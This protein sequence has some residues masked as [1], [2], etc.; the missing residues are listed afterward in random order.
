MGSGS[1]GV[2]AVKQNRKF[3][4]RNCLIQNTSIAEERINQG[5]DIGF[6]VVKASCDSL[7][8]CPPPP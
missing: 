6:D 4:G 5:I 8:K 2:A 7:L 3:I 1:T